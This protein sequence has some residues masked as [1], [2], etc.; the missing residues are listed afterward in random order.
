M[1]HKLILN[2]I[3]SNNIEEPLL[4]NYYTED[5][6]FALMGDDEIDDDQGCVLGYLTA[7]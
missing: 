5:F 3:F 7:S 2:P 6:I 1:K 4:D